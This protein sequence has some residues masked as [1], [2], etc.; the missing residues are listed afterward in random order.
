LDASRGLVAVTTEWYRSDLPPLRG[1]YF[2]SDVPFDL[3]GLFPEGRPLV[4][5]D[6]DADPRFAGA[7]EALAAVGLYSAVNVPLYEDDALTNILVVAMADQPRAWTPEEVAL[8]GAVA[9]QTRATM[10][11]A[12]LRLKEHNIAERLQEALGPSPPEPVP[13]LD[14]D[15]HYDVALEEASIGGDFF[16]VFVVEKG[17]VALVVGD[18]AGK[19]LAAATQ[20]ATVRSMLR[21]ALYRGDRLPEALAQVN[22]ALTEH[23]LLTGFATLFVGLYDTESCRLAYV[24]CGNE[25]ALI[26][27]AAGS[28]MELE[29]TSPVLGVFL[30]GVFEERTVL[31]APGDA[32]I[33]FTDGVTEAGR[34]RGDFLGVRGVAALAEGGGAVESAG[35]L[36]KRITEG[37]KAHAQGQMH[38][39]Q[40]L[41]V[42]VVRG[43]EIPAPSPNL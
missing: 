32:L 22:A 1:E 4:V 19:G 21:F 30:R 31:L 18:L 36:A 15:Y 26:R 29:T 25:P 28:V 39:D 9:A 40:C 20:T 7:Q 10:K 41:L 16:D 17:V 2:L 23:N 14:V 24:S 34:E 11:V 33:A 12:D 38:D 37:V 8:V 35:V 42:A 6:R 13:G 5:V 43:K 3:V 27:R